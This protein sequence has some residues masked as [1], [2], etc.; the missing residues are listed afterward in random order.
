MNA[1]PADALPPGAA[2]E[3]LA[4]LRAWGRGEAPAPPQ[5]RVLDI[6][7]FA[8]AHGVSWPVC[9]ALSTVLPPPAAELLLRPVMQAR[10]ARAGALAAQ[11]RQVVGH[12]SRAGLRPV[13]LKGAA[14]LAEAGGAP[15]PWREMIDLDLMVAPAELPRAVEALRA[16]GYTGDWNAHVPT[17]YHFPA[18]FPR[19]GGVA[20]VE[21]HTRPGWS[22]RG[23]L[24]GLAERAR[25]SALP[26]VLAPAPGDRLAHLVHHAQ[27]ADRG[28]HRRALRPRDMLDW[29][30]LR[31]GGDIDLDRLAARFE[32]AG[33]GPPFRAFA[34]L[35]AW[36]WEDP[37]P[38]GACEAETRWAQQALAALADPAL[39]ETHARR[40]RL[41]AALAALT[42]RETL[43]HAAAGALNPARL[44]RF[45]G[46][47]RG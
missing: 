16:A 36:L 43:A 25:P 19:E 15:L 32:A 30:S 1:P 10:E 46:G 24:R 27:I 38:A 6:L 18:L 22:R 13:A 17:D 42:T 31:E 14:A 29:R 37:A 9:S 26:G 23:P 40:D 20:S 28:F 41:P 3:T 11:F 44:R 45:L 5:A 33:Q 47:R 21:L 12:L 39:A 7:A 8:E 4:L 34:A 35:M 2:G